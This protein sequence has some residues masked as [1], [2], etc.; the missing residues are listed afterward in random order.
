MGPPLVAHSHG[1]DLSGIACSTMALAPF[2]LHLFED[3]LESAVEINFGDE[4][5]HGLHFVS[6]LDDPIDAHQ[7]Q[8]AALPT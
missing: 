1:D 5:Q 2:Q 4:P 8:A 6:V 7:L 3:F